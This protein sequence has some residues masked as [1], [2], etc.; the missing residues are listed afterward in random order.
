MP[1]SKKRIYQMTHPDGSKMNFTAL[2]D[3]DAK[4]QARAHNATSVILKKSRAFR[5]GKSKKSNKAKSRQKR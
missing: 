2:N 4:R 5:G 1:S 3:M